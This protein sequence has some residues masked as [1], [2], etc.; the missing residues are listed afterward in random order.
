V[1]VPSTRAA[2][3]NVDVSCASQVVSVHVSGGE[4]ST[5]PSI[6]HGGF[7]GGLGGARKVISGRKHISHLSAIVH[8]GR[9]FS[10]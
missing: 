4:T 2:Q 6:M 9:W 5:Q 8:T 3:L 10:R 1:S 7:G